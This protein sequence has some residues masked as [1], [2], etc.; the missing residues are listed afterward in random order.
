[1]GLPVCIA[2]YLLTIRATPLVLL[3]QLLLIASQQNHQYGTKLK[4]STFVFYPSS[5]SKINVTRNQSLLNILNTTQKDFKH[6][7]IQKQ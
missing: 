4:E 7:F 2:L 5:V 1:M 6:S 3:P